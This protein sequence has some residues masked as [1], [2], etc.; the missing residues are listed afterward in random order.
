MKIIN[1]TQCVNCRERIPNNKNYG[2][3]ETNYDAVGTYCASKLHIDGLIPAT[4]VRFWQS[5]YPLL[6]MAGRINGDGLCKIGFN[7]SMGLI[8]SVIRSFYI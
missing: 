6:R 7:K 3:N 1:K 5:H 8:F 2:I 4:A